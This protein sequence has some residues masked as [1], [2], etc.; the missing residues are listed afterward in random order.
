MLSLLSALLSTS[1]ALTSPRPV[2]QP[3]AT[4]PTVPAKEARADTTIAATGLAADFAVLRRTLEQL[5][6]GLYRYN[7]REQMQ[8]NFA[9]LRDAWSKDL[10]RREAFLTLTAFTAK[11]RCGHTF[12]NPHNQS[13]AVAKELFAAADK[14]PLAFRWI[15]RRMIVTADFSGSGKLPPGTEVLSINSTSVG[16]ILSQLLTMGRADGSNDDKR[17]DLL[18]ITGTEKLETFDLY[19]PLLFP[20]QGRSFDLSVRPPGAASPTAVTVAPISADARMT[21]RPPVKTDGDAPL[22]KLSY[23]DEQTAYLPMST[24]VAYK[25]KWDWEGF[26]HATFDKLTDE[27]TPNLVIDLRGNEGGSGVGEVILPHLL[28]EAVPVSINDRFVRYQKTPPELDAALDTWDPSFK[29]LTKDTSGPVDLADRQT[30]LA[31]GTTAGF[32]RLRDDDDK[33]IGAEAILTPSPKRYP[34]RV[35]VIIDASNSSA[36][37]GFIQMVKLH[38]LGTL[39]G[40]PTGGNQRGINGGAFFFVRL[41]NSGLEFD[42]PITANFPKPGEPL[43]PDAGITPDVTVPPSVADI[44]AGI[45][46]ELNAVKRL[47]GGQK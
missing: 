33:P 41:A 44:A 3:P 14:L 37:F 24:W 6:P 19:Y 43:R 18:A 5:H 8:A 29:D 4:T 34:G 46:T 21:G 47:I 38:K 40:Q 1:V 12:P 36:T 9:A 22:W 28:R 10:T 13:K 32:F 25:T 23:L 39:V 31:P 7:T 27:N 17:I 11:I 16:T 45:D 15:D 42:L 26:I 35:Y 30:G 2:P 20:L